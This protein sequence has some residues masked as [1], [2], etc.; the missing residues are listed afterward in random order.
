MKAA[1]LRGKN[2]EELKELLEELAAEHLKLRF[3]KATS[4]ITNTARI[5]QVKQEVARIKTVMSERRR[6]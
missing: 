1:D 6:G 3:Q 5:R 2:D 4:Q